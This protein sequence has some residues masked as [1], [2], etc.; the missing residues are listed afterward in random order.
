MV[1]SNPGRGTSVAGRILHICKMEKFIPPFIDMV[2]RNFDG[3]RHVFVLFGNHERYPVSRAQGIVKVGS[4]V[5]PKWGARIRLAREMQDAEKI[6]LHGLF[7]RSVTRLLWLMPWLLRK[8]YWVM[9]GADLYQYESM[10]GARPKHLKELI[11]RSVIRRMGHLV[12]HIG[13]DVELAREWYGATG[14]FHE[15]LMY[16]S[17]VYTDL[18][19]AQDKSSTVNVQIG[20]S[21]DPGNNHLEIIEQLAPL[22]DRD[23]KLHVPLSYRASPYVDSVIEA[24]TRVFGDKFQPLTEFMPLEDYRAFLSTID[25]AIFNHKR[26]QAMGNIINLLGLGKKVYL[27]PEITPW[28]TLRNK[29]IVVYDVARIDIDTFDANALAR[30][31]D[32]VRCE[33]S[34]DRLKQQLNDLFE[35]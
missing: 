13:G 20:N 5:I 8:C 6:V 28:A 9:W 18:P 1:L 29:G 2:D 30:N 11:R 10:G 14:Q 22:K 7:N 26:Q 27:R 35:G 24:G 4:G 21:A 23:I 33:Y 19:L 15:C 12:T 32:L 31:R 34:E 16:A 17:N 3:S 25:V